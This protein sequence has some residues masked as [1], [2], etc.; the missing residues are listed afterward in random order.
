MIHRQVN[1]EV[2]PL[3][4]LLIHSIHGGR[5]SNSLFLPQRHHDLSMQQLVGIII[6]TLLNDRFRCVS[7]LYE[8]VLLPPSSDRGDDS[9]RIPSIDA[10][11][12]G[13]GME[14]MMRELIRCE[15]G[16]VDASNPVEIR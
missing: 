7:L 5:C 8:T 11:H 4:N 14:R 2:P 9:H 16:D 13:T 3:I 15:I 12:G 6:S 10:W 1:L